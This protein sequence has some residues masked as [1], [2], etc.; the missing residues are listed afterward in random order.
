LI[1]PAETPTETLAFCEAPTPVFWLS[2]WIPAKFWNELPPV[3]RLL[4]IE[5]EGVRSLPL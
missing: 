3:D 4:S 1:A 2:D 5:P